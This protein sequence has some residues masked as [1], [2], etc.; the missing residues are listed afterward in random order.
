MQVNAELVRI[1]NLP[2]GYDMASDLRNFGEKLSLLKQKYQGDFNEK[3]V[4]D[5]ITASKFSTIEP[6]DIEG[7]G[8]CRDNASYVA[9]SIVSASTAT[10]ASLACSFGIVLFPAY[11]VCQAA[12]AVG[13]TAAIY[14][15][16]RTYCL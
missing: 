13:Q 11:L 2:L 5:V 4:L 12:V 3:N 14:L 16:Y 9:C 7:E 6:A 10:T 15:R 8:P 1:L